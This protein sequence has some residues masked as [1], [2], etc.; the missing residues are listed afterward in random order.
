MKLDDAQALASVIEIATTWN[1]RGMAD[2]VLTEVRNYAASSQERNDPHSAWDF[3]GDDI[4]RD[5]V[6]HAVMSRDP[7]H[8]RLV[9]EAVRTLVKATLEK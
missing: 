1:V 9:V 2:E 8:A 4:L 5:T 3:A 7:D 6:Y